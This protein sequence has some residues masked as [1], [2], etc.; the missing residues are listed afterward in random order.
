MLVGSVVAADPNGSTT[1]C[2]FV[3]LS[4]GASSIGTD[5]DGWTFTLLQNAT[6]T[7]M[8]VTIGGNSTNGNLCGPVVEF[9]PGDLVAIQAIPNGTTA[10][11]TVN[12]TVGLSY[13]DVGC[14]S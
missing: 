9:C 1:S 12:V 10:A 13:V 5:A 4:T 6:P 11:D 7:P 3:A 8:T 14:I 2:M